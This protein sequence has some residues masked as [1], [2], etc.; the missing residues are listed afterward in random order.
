MLSL[1]QKT[2]RRPGDGRLKWDLWCFHPIWVT[3]FL[4]VFGNE[5]TKLLRI[6]LFIFHF[7]CWPAIKGVKEPKTKLPKYVTKIEWWV[8]QMILIWLSLA[9][10]IINLKECIWTLVICY[11][12]FLLKLY[13]LNCD[14]RY[15]QLE[16]QKEKYKIENVPH[17]HSVYVCVLKF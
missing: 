7:L 14:K 10:R 4:V 9:R 12:I 6:S 16:N 3:W 15:I 17:S 2:F 13:G 1:I 11:H 8:Q 5:V